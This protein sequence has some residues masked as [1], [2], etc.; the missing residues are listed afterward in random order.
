MDTEEALRRVRQITPMLLDNITTAVLSRAVLGA[1]NDTI[2]KGL[3]GVDS[4]FVPTFTA[5]QNALALKLSLDLA[6]ILDLSTGK[7]AYPPH[8]QT[9]ASIPVLAALIA[10][11]DVQQCLEQA[12]EKWSSGVDHIG[13]VEPAPS[14]VREAAISALEESNRFDDRDCCREAIAG[15][16]AVA[17][18]LDEDGSDDKAALVRVRDFRNKWLAHSLFDEEPQTPSFADLFMLLERAVEAGRHASLAVEGVNTEFDD[19]TQL[20]RENADGYY[21]CVLDG[22]KRAAAARP[23]GLSE[24]A[25][26][27]LLWPSIV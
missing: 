26:C 3:V 21:A 25:A 10:R 1:A 15:F 6:R 11:A 27:G 18:R 14:G 4:D 9:K 20:R 12:A 19:Q 13:T 8:K 23:Q 24:L 22:L 17:A 2:P 7:R 5:I 16:L